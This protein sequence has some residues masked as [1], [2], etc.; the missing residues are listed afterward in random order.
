LTEDD[1]KSS[2]IGKYIFIAILTI[3]AAFAGLEWASREPP[4]TVEVVQ[5][6]KPKADTTPPQVNQQAPAPPADSQPLA[7]QKP[8]TQPQQS[9]ATEKTATQSSS[10]QPAPEKTAAQARVP[11]SENARIQ[12]TSAAPSQTTAEAAANETDMTGT[13]ELTMAEGYLSG[14]YGNARNTSEAAR[15]LWKSVAKQNSTASVLLANL[16][17]QGDG[18]SKNCDQ[19]RLLLV[20]A[21]KKGSSVAAQN[22]RNLE[23]GGCK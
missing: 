15:W 16:Y 10:E 23:S 1:S 3:G 4:K 13:Q 17:T 5:G 9:P 19:A 20:A 14:R 2:G 22:L 7:T 18:V 11:A 8:P 6:G 21:A 12:R